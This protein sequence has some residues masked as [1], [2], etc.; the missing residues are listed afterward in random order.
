MSS[1]EY[2]LR[3]EILHLRCVMVEAAEEILSFWHVHSGD[4]GV[5]PHRLIDYLTG[6]ETVSAESN[7]YPNRVDSVRGLDEQ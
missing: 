4:G 2:E 6:R 7:P 3:K 5:G 1:T